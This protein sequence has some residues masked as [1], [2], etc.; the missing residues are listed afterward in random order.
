M[1]LKFL[2]FKDFYDMESLF[3]RR[4]GKVW[5]DGDF[6]TDTKCKYHC[7]PKGHP[8]Q[9]GPEWQYGCLHVAWLQ[10]PYDFCPMVKCGGDPARCE[11]P[12]IELTRSEEAELFDDKEEEI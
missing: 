11:I 7:L 6:P 1:K 12:R 4:G 5:I 3:F 8:L 9:V 10:N 2:R